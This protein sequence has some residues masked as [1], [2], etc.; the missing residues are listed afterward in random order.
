MPKLNG[1][2]H[3]HLKMSSLDRFSNFVLEQKKSGQLI[4]RSSSVWVSVT[5]KCI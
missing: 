2:V 1:D 3:G 5:I 4:A